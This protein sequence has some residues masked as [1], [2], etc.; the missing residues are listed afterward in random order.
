MLEE[1]QSQLRISCHVSPQ[2]FSARRRARGANDWLAT[3]PPTMMMNSRRLPPT[4]DSSARERYKYR[5]GSKTRARGIQPA[6]LT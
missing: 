3:A 2:R 5:T 6:G 1:A 4:V